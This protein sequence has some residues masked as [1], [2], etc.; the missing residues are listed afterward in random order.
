MIATIFYINVP[1][2]IL[3][4]AFKPDVITVAGVGPVDYSKLIQGE[5][6]YGQVC[7][8][9]TSMV[10]KMGINPF[11]HGSVA[12][13]LGNTSIFHQGFGIWAG[14]IVNRKV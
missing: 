6:Q 9:A 14:D 13:D 7:T 4:H 12:T 8:D 1:T 11:S 2:L 5:A 3:S 10:Q